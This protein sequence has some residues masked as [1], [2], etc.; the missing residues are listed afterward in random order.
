MK[1]KGWLKEREDKIKNFYDIELKKI[2]DRI[3]I[4]EVL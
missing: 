4:A 2:E 1:F 3:L